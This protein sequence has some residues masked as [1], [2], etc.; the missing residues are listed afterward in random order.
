MKIKETK[1][2]NL[3]TKEQLEIDG[4]NYRKDEKL[5]NWWN[6]ITTFLFG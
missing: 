2:V 5:S 1:L 6:M 3:T 4:G